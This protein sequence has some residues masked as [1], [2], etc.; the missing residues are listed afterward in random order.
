MERSAPGGDPQADW[1]S[2]RRRLGERLRIRR[3][4]NELLATGLFDLPWYLRHNPDLVL[5]VIDPVAHWLAAG[6]KEGRDPNPMFGSSWYRSQNP[7]VANAGA[8]P[9]EHYLR[10]GTLPDRDP[11][12]LFQTPLYVAAQGSVCTPQEAPRHFAESGKDIAPGAYRNAEVLA[13]HQESYREVRSRLT[14]PALAVGASKDLGPDRQSLRF[15]LCQQ[16]PLSDRVSTAGKASGNQGHGLHDLLQ[17][18][19][20][21]LM[22]YAYVLL[23][24]DDLHIEEGGIDDLFASA[25]EEALDLAQPSLSSD[26]FGHHQ[27]FFTRGRW[28]VR[29]VNGVEIMMPLISHRALEARAHLFS[30]T[31]S[32]W[33]LD[34]ALSKIVKEQLNGRAAVVDHIVAWHTKPIDLKGGAFYAMLRRQN[35]FPLL[36]YRY[37]QR[38]YDAASGFH[39]V[40][41]GPGQGSQDEREGE[42]PS[43][44][45]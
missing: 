21:T 33:G 36:Q 16:A 5:T 14:S 10:T 20:D 29:Y 17:R 23:L 39:E 19:P 13:F 45:E 35:I 28:S 26:S 24:D 7:E 4:A 38:V 9:L 11:N 6:S 1:W 34:I 40:V 37:L 25:E 22:A 43:T 15:D 41:V 42:T 8:N 44:L 18:W 2:L 3:L 12:P 31:V 30:E 27:V 32:G